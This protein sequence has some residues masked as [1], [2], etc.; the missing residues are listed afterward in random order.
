VGIVDY[1]IWYY[2]QVD[3]DPRVAGAVQR[4]DAY[5]LNP[6]NAKAYGLLNAG[7]DPGPKDI[8][9]CF[10]TATALTGRALAD[11]LS[12]GVDARW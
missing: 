1:L 7:A 5:V 12:P 11:I 3:R 8:N 9:N 2:E 10:N 4:W 6:E